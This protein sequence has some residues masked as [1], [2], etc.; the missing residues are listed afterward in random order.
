MQGIRTK[1][2]VNFLALVL[3]S[4]VIA[5]GPGLHLFSFAYHTGDQSYILLVP[6]LSAMLVRRESD[7]VFAAVS[8]GISRPAVLAFAVG[9]LLIGGAYGSPAGSELQLALTGLGLVACWVGAFIYCFGLDAARKAAFPLGMLLWI[10]PIP[11]VIVDSF[12]Y[13]LQVGSAD[14]VNV[15]FNMTGLP[16]LREGKFIFHLAQQSIEVAKECSGIR[17]S[18]CLILLTMVIAHESLGGNFRRSILLL[19]TVPIVILKNGVRIVTLTL[20][21]IYIDPS[22]LTGPLHHDGGIVFFLIGMV[23]LIPVIWVLKRGDAQP[24][25]ASQAAAAK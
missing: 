19:S 18:L 4:M 2:L 1:D 15:L 16:V 11:S 23:M 8:S 9:I 25:P 14:C 5:V 7:G 21:A 10:I 3:A 6:V 24:A 13:F 20:G 12:R 22:F 17:S